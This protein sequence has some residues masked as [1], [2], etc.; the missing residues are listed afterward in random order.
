MSDFVPGNTPQGD[1]TPS[2][3]PAAAPAAP[4]APAPA[5]TPNIGAPPASATPSIPDGYVPSYR[6]RE[7]REAAL[8]QANDQW[9]QRETQYQTQLEQLQQQMR[10]VLGV[11]Q[12]PNPQIEQVKQ[13][14]SQLF[15]GV[16]SL[17]DKAE[18]LAA[19]IERSQDMEQQNTH[20]WQSYGR[21]TLDRLFN[22]AQE[23]MGQPLTDEAKRFLHSNFIGFIQSSPELEQRYSQDPSIVEDFWKAFSSNFID[24]A[25]RVTS[26]GIQNRVPGALPQDTPS[27][28][29]R[30]TP[31]PQ[32]GNLDDRVASAWAQY[33]QTANSRQ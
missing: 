7:A 22:R 15:P 32:P 18:K 1:A 8:R 11:S 13:Q 29:P 20:Y 5:A 24:P 30:S 27:G 25:R 17:E 28:A 14:F 12:P 21:Q 33:Q 2:P 16:S 23:T 6:L 26:A 10:A 19:L 9:T 4:A 31:A 3:A